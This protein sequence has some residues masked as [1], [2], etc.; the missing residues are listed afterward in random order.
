MYVLRVRKG[1]LRSGSGCL[2]GVLHTNGKSGRGLH[3]RE[4][5]SE[6]DLNDGSSLLFASFSQIACVPIPY[7]NCEW[8]ATRVSECIRTMLA[9]HYDFYGTMEFVRANDVPFIG[10]RYVQVLNAPT[11]LIE[12]V[13]ELVQDDTS[14]RQKS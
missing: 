4:G 13:T 3:H 6:K 9:R 5:G 14:L 7:R 10:S 11:M 8:S 1:P 2:L 12:G